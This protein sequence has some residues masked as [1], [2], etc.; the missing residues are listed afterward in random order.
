MCEQK[1]QVLYNAVI[2]SCKLTQKQIAEKC[3][4]FEQQW[5][6]NSAAQW[7]VAAP[8]ADAAAAAA[9]AAAGA[10]HKYM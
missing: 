10:C 8:V 3:V 7:R 2:K 4:G 5:I 6:L 1:I 9:A